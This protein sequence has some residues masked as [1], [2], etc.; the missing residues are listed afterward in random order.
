MFHLPQTMRFVDA[1]PEQVFVLDHIAKP[2]IRENV[3]S[4]WR[5]NMTELAKRPNVYCKLSGMATE[6]DWQSGAA[7]DLVKRTVAAVS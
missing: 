1:H 4:P 5:E 7:L 2:R 6:A 3:L